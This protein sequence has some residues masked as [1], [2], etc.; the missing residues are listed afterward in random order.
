MIH[1]ANVFKRNVTRVPGDRFTAGNVEQDALRIF[2]DEEWDEM[3]RI[4]AVF[5]NTT[6][7]TK[8]VDVEGNVCAVP[9]EVLECSAGLLE[10]CFVG[11]DD[12]SEN[13][14]LVTAKMREPWPIDQRGPVDGDD[15]RGATPDAYT[16]LVQ[17]VKEIEDAQSDL[18][19]STYA[20]KTDIPTDY[21]SINDFREAHE[22]INEALDA[23]LTEIPPE[24]VT[25]EELNAKGYQT[26]EQVSTIVNEALGVITDGS[27]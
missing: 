21:V 23:C 17:R 13:A 6:G 3:E 14:R 19:L 22:A 20:K 18:D 1:S 10:V 15:S 4:H 9:W 7:A 5:T 12:D 24:Y 26:A 25:E 11:Y 16:A 27:Y 2:F 8:R